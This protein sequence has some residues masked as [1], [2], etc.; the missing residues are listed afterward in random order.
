VGLLV[1]V[2]VVCGIIGVVIGQAKNRVGEGM[3]LGCVLGPLG[4]LVGVLMG[5]KSTRCPACREKI[6]AGATICP[7]CRQPLGTAPVP[8]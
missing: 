7:H 6:Q 4:L 1:L 3:L 8:Q 2:S 5:D